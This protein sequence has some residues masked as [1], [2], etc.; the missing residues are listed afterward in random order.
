MDGN[1][2]T[3]LRAVTD[4]LTHHTVEFRSRPFVVGVGIMEEKVIIIFLLLSFPSGSLHQN[5]GNSSWIT[6]NLGSNGKS[7]ILFF[8]PY[9][10]WC[11]EMVITESPFLSV[12]LSD[13]FDNLVN[14]YLWFY[15]TVLYTLL[16]SSISLRLF[17]LKREC[18]V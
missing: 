6:R 12:C 10:K 1:L 3:M 14:Y 11:W 4:P 5:T 18:L 7:F 8:I 9:C 15:N 13:N 17:L 2:G 16:T